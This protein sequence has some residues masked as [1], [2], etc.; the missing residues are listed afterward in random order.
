M[1]RSTVVEGKSMQQRRRAWVRFACDLDVTC[2]A[3]GAMKDAGWPGKI[4]NISAAGVGLL[5]RH[6][7][8]RGMEL[9]VE[10]INRSGNRHTVVARVAHVTAVI[11]SG[12]P[13]WLVG[14]AFPQA[15]AQDELEALQEEPVANET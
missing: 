5:L 9:A 2:R 3:T 11:A 4:A 15:L 1:A 14:C 7:F 13:V 6:R 12:N 10:I 8:E